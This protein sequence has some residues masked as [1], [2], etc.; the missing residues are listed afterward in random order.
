M[1]ARR[2]CRQSEE[3]KLQQR[4]ETTRFGERLLADT[5]IIGSELARGAGGEKAA[6]IVMD[7]FTGISSVNAFSSKTEERHIES[8]LLHTGDELESNVTIRTDCAP[9]LL[10][11][12]RAMR[13]I[14]LSLIHI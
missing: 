2:H 7:S 4:S 11:A 5:I 13:W 1:T 14:A 9:D 8:L 12:V 3:D 6:D 10:A